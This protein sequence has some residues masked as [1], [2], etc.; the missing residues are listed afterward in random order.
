M[1]QVVSVLGSCHGCYPTVFTCSVLIQFNT[2]SLLSLRILSSLLF[3]K[4]VQ[5]KVSLN[6]Y[7]QTNKCKQYAQILLFQLS[8]ISTL[9]LANSMYVSC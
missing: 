1:T 3:N 8:T 7:K 4:E 2:C 9:I 5:L 6:I